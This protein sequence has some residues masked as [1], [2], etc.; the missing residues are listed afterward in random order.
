MMALFRATQ[1]GFRILTTGPYTI[2][3]GNVHF[4][5]TMFWEIWDPLPLG[6]KLTWIVFATHTLV[7]ITLVEILL[8]K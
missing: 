1:K 7:L 6:T 2:L 8:F 5:K 3:A 4:W